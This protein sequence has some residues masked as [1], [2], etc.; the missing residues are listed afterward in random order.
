[1]KMKT[2]ILQSSIIAMLLLG[3]T[4][5]KAQISSPDGLNVS[6][7]DKSKAIF[8]YQGDTFTLRATTD[9][10]NGQTFDS[11]KWEREHNNDGSLTEVQ[12]GSSQTLAN[13]GSLE[14]GYYTFWVTGHVTNDQ[15]TNPDVVCSAD[16]ETF[17]V[18][19]LPP[20]NVT[21]LP[22]G[23]NGNLLYCSND[24]PD[25]LVLTANVVQDPTHAVSE[26]FTYKYQW[27]KAEG[28]GTPQAITGA[29]NQTYTIND[30]NDATAGTFQYSV[31]ASLEIKD[32]CQYNSLESATNGSVD[33]IVTPK[34]TK[35][36]ISIE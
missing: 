33:I 30:T 35:P 13:T 26:E 24:L 21:V 23:N 19:V 20:L 9:A 1:M 36:S 32:A 2:T 3:F 14:P 28:I 29:T 15:G 34:P 8:C 22:S 12:N 18:Y 25:D 10:G 31:I 6:G 11:F 17:T 5:L 7:D 16:P 4:S 27:Y